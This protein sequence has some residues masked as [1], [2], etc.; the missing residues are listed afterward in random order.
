VSARVIKP[1]EDTE[2]TTLTVTETCPCGA[3]YRS[4]RR[5][6]ERVWGP[7]ATWHAQ[8]GFQWGR[9]GGDR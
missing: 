3:T 5:R 4:G 7:W 9:P 2:P 1:A 6:D 8:H